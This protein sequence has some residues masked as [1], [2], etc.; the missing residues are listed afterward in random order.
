MLP[1]SSRDTDVFALQKGMFSPDREPHPCVGEVK[2]LMQPVLFW[3]AYNGQPKDGSVPSSPLKVQVAGKTVTPVVLGLTNRY[4]FRD[5]SHLVWSWH[6]KSSQSSESVHADSFD[7]VHGERVILDFYDSKILPKIQQLEKTK[8]PAGNKYFL[9][10][11]GFLKAHTSWADAGHVLVSQQFPLQFEFHEPI[12][13]QIISSSQ[14]CSSLKV[15]QN[16]TLV[17]VTR[18]GARNFAVP[19]AIVHKPTGALVQYAPDGHN[20]LEGSGVVPNFTRAATDNDRGGLEMALEFLFPGWYGHVLH[21]LLHSR[22]E[23]SHWSRWRKVGL[24]Q[25]SPPETTCVDLRISEGEDTQQVRITC[26]CHLLS[27]RRRELII[28]L[29]IRYTIYADGRVRVAHHVVPQKMLRKVLSLPRVGLHFQVDAPHYRIGYFGR[30][31]GEVSSLVA[32]RELLYV[33]I[34]T[35]LPVTSSPNRIILIERTDPKWGCTRRLPAICIRSTL[36]PARTDLGPTASGYAS[37]ER[38]AP[39]CA[40]LPLPRMEE[41]L[42]LA[43]ARCCIARLSWK[44]RV[45]HVT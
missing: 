33:K 19:L 9:N 35:N 12:P 5:L 24:A 22:D 14:K 16:D 34:I 2:F 10:L 4:S 32:C 25:D 26:D 3:P 39:A 23:F 40:L 42:N 1:I 43:S 21:G 15:S 31:P 37:D 28:K 38:T 20:L 8:P 7:V 27:T 17:R 11:R 45:T 41:H 36:F 18:N 13:R 30:G 6:I 29:T 44:G